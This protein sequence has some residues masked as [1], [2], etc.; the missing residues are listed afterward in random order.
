MAARN[1][2]MDNNPFIG[3]GKL[4]ESEEEE[5]VEYLA[6]LEWKTQAGPQE[7]ARLGAMIR[8]EIARRKQ[9]S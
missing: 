6:A 8:A 4:F 5:F 3:A 2:F 7:V 1:D 9:Q